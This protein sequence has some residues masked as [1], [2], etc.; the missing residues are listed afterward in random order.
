MAHPLDGAFERVTRAGEHIDDLVRQIKE[1]TRT[2]EQAVLD[3]LDLQPGTIK[4]DTVILPLGAN[5]L[6][7]DVPSRY[8]ILVGETFYN[9][10]AALD[11][12]VYE[13][14]R[15]DTGIPQ[16]RTQFPITDTPERFFGRAK[17]PP[18]MAQ[19][20]ARSYD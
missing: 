3:G 13:L 6:P 14:A 2:S 1:L 10:R 20:R 4:L 17:I 8:S 11:Y 16:E 12:L 15:R 18:E 9:L 5:I 19:G 7:F